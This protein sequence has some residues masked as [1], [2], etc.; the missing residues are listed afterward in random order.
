V[1]DAAG[2]FI[3]D[4]IDDLSPITQPL[5][6]G[7]WG[8][9]ALVPHTVWEALHA[10]ERPQTTNYTHQ[11][12]WLEIHQNGYNHHCAYMKSIAMASCHRPRDVIDADK[13]GW[14][15]FT[16]VPPLANIAE[17]LN[18]SRPRYVAKLV[19]ATLRR[20][21]GDHP[22][23]WIDARCPADP[24]LPSTIT[25]DICPITCSGFKSDEWGPIAKAGSPKAADVWIPIHGAPSVI[26]AWKR[27]PFWREWMIEIAIT[28]KLLKE[29]AA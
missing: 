24:S 5:R 14:R 22:T 16:T 9:A 17:E 23:I 29:E 27:S 8:D 10:E 20:L 19:A 1:A 11:W 7:G 12:R 6:L 18:V 4:L 28:Q 2:V 3:G 21:K 26:A 13:L 15:K 25:C